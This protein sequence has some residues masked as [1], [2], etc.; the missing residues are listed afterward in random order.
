M[1]T[2]GMSAF[3]WM[4]RGHHSKPELSRFLAG[5]GLWLIVFELSVMRVVML[6]QM[7]VKGNVVLLI[8]LWVIGLSMIA[9]SVLIYLPT[10]VLI[11]ISVAV[12]TLHNLLDRFPAERFGRLAWLWQI[13]HQQGAFSFF[14]ITFAVAYPV[15]PWI[16]VMAGGYCLGAVMLWQPDR[17]QKFLVRLGALLCLGFVPVRAVNIYGDPSRWS[18]QATPLYTVLSFLNTTKYP[19]S[20]EF[21][22][23]TLG[24]ALIALALLERRQFSSANP[25]IVFGRVPFFFYAA[26][27]AVAHLVMIALAVVRYGVHPFLLLAPPSMGTLAELFPQNFGYPLWVAF[28]VWLVVLAV[29]YP[30]CLWFSRLKQ[31]RN[32]WWLSYL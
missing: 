6:S 30:P 32:A 28:A 23:M 9:L 14:G 16:G 15:L 22:L 26:H 31:R 4:A 17:R 2:A 5:R 24:P 29:L 21:L 18:P 12:M 27:I 1:L 7:S 3:L 20:F 25:L 8:I 19:P 13:L 11:A 10:Q